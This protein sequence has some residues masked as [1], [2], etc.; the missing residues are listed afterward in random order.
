MLRHTQSVTDE[1][2]NHGGE[3]SADSGSWWRNP[4]ITV[5][6]IAAILAAILG[7]VV[8]AIL[9]SG[10]SSSSGGSPSP[11][12]AS[13]TV[14]PTGPT[15]SVP[16][17]TTNPPNPAQTSSSSAALWRHMI[18]LPYEHG[19]DIDSP[20]PNSASIPNPNIDFYTAIYINNEPGFSFGSSTAGLAE[21]SSPSY[22][23]CI[24]AIGTNAISS[25]S[26]T[27]QVGQTI[28][29]KSGSAYPHVAVIRVVKW[30]PNS[31]NMV[32]NVTVWAANPSK[33]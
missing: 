4:V 20:T 13:A 26:Y 18:N 7:G 21:T 10:S 32:V 11:S 14:Q 23:Q 30:D 12:G 15:S 31:M 3:M 9:Q 19:V 27:T 28:C 17:N 22:Q 29:V 2:W 33:E 24:D 1:E 5:P 8:T 16:N 6:A 25:S